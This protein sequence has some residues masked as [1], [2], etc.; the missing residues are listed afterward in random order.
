M[1][2]P[3]G[4]HW[5]KT[6]L[7]AALAF[8]V[9]A[10][11]AQWDLDGERSRLSFISV[12]NASVG[13]SHTF[14]SLAGSVGDDGQARVDIDLDSVETAIPIRNSRMRE[15]LFETGTFPSAS[16]TTTVD[17][18]VIAQAGRAPTVVTMPF[19]VAL[20]GSSA[21][22]DAAVL[23][24]VDDDGSLHVAT[25]EPIVVDAG[26]FDLGAGVTA[27]KEVAGLASISSSVPVSAHLVF[28]A[29]DK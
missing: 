10:A 4:Y 9:S 26:D 27:L 17:P 8:F 19:T 5:L 12:K 22:Y 14:T 21:D 7:G 3:T 13:E 18:D 15:M 29:A 1:M 11:S 2:K 24:S 6:C 23:V 25:R 28:D 20:H 16:I